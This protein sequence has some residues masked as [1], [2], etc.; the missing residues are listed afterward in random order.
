MLKQLNYGN[1][2]QNYSSAAFIVRKK[3]KDH[4]G[5]AMAHRDS[6]GIPVDYLFMPLQSRNKLLKN[7]VILGEWNFDHSA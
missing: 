2:S 1:N 6:H 4:S 7:N 3:L 5:L